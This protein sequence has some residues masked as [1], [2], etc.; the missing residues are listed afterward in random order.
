MS[1][2]FTKRSGIAKEHVS[3]F[4][5]AVRQAAK[6]AHI[7]VHNGHMLLD[8]SDSPREQ[9]AAIKEFIAVA[10][11]EVL[12]RKDPELSHTLSYIHHD[13]LD[14][15]SLLAP[16]SWMPAQQY[17]EAIQAELGLLRN[18][19]MH[20]LANA[21]P[22]IGDLVF[23]P[24]PEDEDARKIKMTQLGMLFSAHNHPDAIHPFG[25]QDF[26]VERTPLEPGL[27]MHKDTLAQ[28]LR[29]ELLPPDTRR[30]PAGPTALFRT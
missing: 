12:G 7:E 23:I 6:L 19:L 11:S 2:S 29:S 16:P 13:T 22:G 8:V 17:A 1:R 4:D 27:L 20:P 26:T 28:V 15:I 21:E 25:R 14:T 30:R 10:A 24:L 5:E 18:Q 9:T 3:V